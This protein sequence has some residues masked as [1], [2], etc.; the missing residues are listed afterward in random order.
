MFIRH[1]LAKGF[2]TIPL[3]NLVYATE[4]QKKGDYINH[5]G[6]KIQGDYGGENVRAQKHRYE[7]V[8]SP[9]EAREFYEKLGQ[10]LERFDSA[11]VES[12]LDKDAVS[13]EED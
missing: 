1:F 9:D 7:V 8:F 2:N 12:V 11:V 3:K 13:V 4:H 5:V 10:M 6:W